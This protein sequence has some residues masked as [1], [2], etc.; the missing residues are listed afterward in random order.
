[1]KLDLNK[2]VPWNPKAKAEVFL[3]NMSVNPRTPF[4]LTFREISELHKSPTLGLSE[5]SI[6]IQAKAT[7][8]WLKVNSFASS[9]K[10]LRPDL[11]D[12]EI[13]LIH[14]VYGTIPDNVIASMLNLT[15]VRVRQ[16]RKAT[17]QM[18]NKNKVDIPRLPLVT[19]TDTSRYWTEDELIENYNITEDD[20]QI[21]HYKD[22]LRGL[23]RKSEDIS[24]PININSTYK[25]DNKGRILQ[26]V[27]LPS[28]V[29]EKD[30]EG[31]RELSNLL[32]TYVSREERFSEVVSSFDGR[33]D[34]TVNY[35][36]LASSIPS[37]SEVSIE[38]YSTISTKKGKKTISHYHTD[39]SF[40]DKLRIPSLVINLG[41]DMFNA[42]LDSKIFPPALEYIVVELM[43]GFRYIS[44]S[45]NYA[46]KDLSYNRGHCLPIRTNNKA[47]YIVN[48]PPLVYPKF[49][50][51]YLRISKDDPRLTEGVTKDYLE[52][53]SYGV[54]CHECSTF[55]SPHT[56]TSCSHLKFLLLE[57][58]KY[59]RGR[60]V[61]IKVPL[62]YL[63]F[64]SNSQ[65]SFSLYYYEHK[66]GSITRVYT[67]N[68]LQMY[69]NFSLPL[70]QLPFEP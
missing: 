60:A 22:L 65:K 7:N 26:G 30:K 25:E 56:K 11:E 15:P 2:L 28:Q 44:K 33:A 17:E 45:S 48:T 52:G 69:S 14:S 23:K 39:E 29:L 64:A 57:T 43:I 51:D 55:I 41:V 34:H 12:I 59:T 9:E 50:S 63:Y 4:N 16:I 62:L 61:T 49:A 46:I 5:E 13:A 6:K 8:K 47:N 1:M 42:Y 21:T 66:L 36:K 40:S 38:Y 20:L 37:V 70:H 27:P 68:L 54:T 32:W 58:N 53:Y 10:P 18:Y 19:I 24:F 3:G 31:Y 67:L 35:L